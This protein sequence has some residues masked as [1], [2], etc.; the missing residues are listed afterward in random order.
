MDFENKVE[1]NNLKLVQKNKIII[2]RGSCQP[3]NGAE[4]RQSLSKI[5]NDV[6]KFVTT[7][8]EQF[9]DVRHFLCIRVQF[10]SRNLLV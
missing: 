3:S 1:E 7:F 8:F 2:I 4:C 9:S 5:R 6:D 10:V